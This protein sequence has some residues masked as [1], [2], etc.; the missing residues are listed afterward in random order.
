MNLKKRIE[1]VK[2]KR[3]YS[4]LAQK[5][6]IEKIIEKLSTIQEG[7]EANMSVE[8]LKK[9]L[10]EIGINAKMIEGKKADSFAEKYHEHDIYQEKTE[11]EEWKSKVSTDI[12]AFVNNFRDE[13]ERLSKEKEVSDKEIKNT[14]ET[15]SFKVETFQKDV[16]TLR[17]RLEKKA[18][19][20]KKELDDLYHGYLS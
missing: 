15:F 16:L 9:T 18:T 14:N 5:A 8:E 19:E 4:L 6:I 2:A 1:T 11:A 3:S 20:L 10:E 13:I 7:A 17:D 12:I